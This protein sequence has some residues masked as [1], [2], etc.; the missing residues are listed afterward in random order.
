M[1]KWTLCE[2]AGEDTGFASLPHS[3][4]QVFHHLPSSKLCKGQKFSI[5]FSLLNN[6][7]ILRCCLIQLKQYFLMQMG[8]EV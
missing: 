7:K 4:A 6:A 1:R 8:T 3:R 2:V 5:L